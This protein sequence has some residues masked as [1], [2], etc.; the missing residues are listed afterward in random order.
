M[1]VDFPC[2]SPLPW[3][4]ALPPL[5]PVASPVALLVA[6]A[7]GAAAWPLAG[8]A[9]PGC[10][11]MDAEEASS[12]CRSGGAA[13]DGPDSCWEQGRTFVACCPRAPGAVSSDCIFM[14]LAVVILLALCARDA[15]HWKLR[16]SEQ[17]ARRLRRLQE[18]QREID[19]S[20][21]GQFEGMQAELSPMKAS[22]AWLTNLLGILQKELDIDFNADE[23]DR[24]APLPQRW[25]CHVLVAG[26]AALADA[27][28]FHTDLLR[29]FAS[30]NCCFSAGQ[31]QPRL[32]FALARHLPA[33]ELWEVDVLSCRVPA[34]TSPAS[35]AAIAEEI[36]EVMLSGRSLA[37]ALLP[38]SR[39][40]RL[41]LFGPDWKLQKCTLAS[42]KEIEVIGKELFGPN[43]L[44]GHTGH[45]Y[46]MAALEWLLAAT[47]PN[48]FSE[49]PRGLREV[50]RQ[51]TDATERAWR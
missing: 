4:V 14:I 11:P 37:S 19:E 15:R 41:E 31:G 51:L 48:P 30:W 49:A 40:C 27:E 13:E 16:R 28:G 23:D 36:I 47:C 33:E 24:I 9:A 22:A 21:N 26:E 25:H 20:Q 5:A 3:R 45:R 50:S 38:V 46:L 2:A 29:L 35:W 34:R 42:K 18:M 39:I 17:G 8:V 1:M 10:W 7:Q 12:C 32:Y 44:A 6:M 43:G